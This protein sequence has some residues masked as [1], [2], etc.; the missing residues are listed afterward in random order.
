MDAVKL[1]WTICA[2]VVITA[3]P[4]LANEDQ[5]TLSPY[6]FVAGDEPSVEQFPLK[7][8]KVEVTISGVIAD[9]KVIQY[10]ENNGAAPINGSYIFPGSTRAAVHGMKMRIGERLITA[11]IKEKEAARQIFEA[12]K[13]AGKSASLLAQKRPNVFS[14]E[15]ANIMPGD[16]LTVELRYTELLIPAEGVYE[17]VY[18]TVVGPRY[19]TMDAETS[20]PSERWV[21]NPYL[22]EGDAPRTNFAISMAINAGMDIE[23]IASPSHDTIVSY[24]DAQRARIELAET[25]EFGG[26]RDVIVRYQLAGATISSGL[27]LHRGEDENF[28]LLMAQPP[29]RVK[30]EQIPAREYIFVVDVS[31]SMHGFPLNT[32]KKLMNRLLGGLRPSDRFNVLLFAG[33]SE[34][35]AP[36]SVPATKDGINKAIRFINDSEGGGGTEL[37]AAMRRAMALPRAES[38]S[39]SLAIITDGYINA[40]CSVFEEIE[41]NLG[42]TNVF[43]FGIGSGVNRYLIEGM[44]RAGRGYPFVVTEP[45]QAPGAAAQFADYIATPLLTEITLTSS[46]VELYD[47]EPAAIPDLFASRPILVYGKWKE[48]ADKAALTISGKS[49]GGEYRQ[50]FAFSDAEDGADNQPLAYLWARARIARLSDYNSAGHDD[51]LRRRIVSL[52]LTYNLLTKFTSFVAVDEIVRNPDAQA[53]DVKQP[54][55]LPKGVSNL[56]VG[57][58]MRNYSEPSLAHIIGLFVLLLGCFILRDYRRKHTTA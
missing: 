2:V 39:R 34:I 6:F 18:P 11:K 54:L 9:V 33:G 44:A 29:K 23:K 26:D 47:V 36:S 25:G 24:D 17:F 40:E 15:V 20:P 14:M 50:S 1:L 12:A 21:A 51:E 3:G 31:G 57:A 46:E 56:A 19:S 30:P 43:S 27:L 45:A 8:T 52:G 13:K 32:A 55:P 22:K 38:V 41:K 48:A 5:Q 10:Y 58:G 53:T 4:G 7:D 42:H 35:M 49:A 37:L 16:N 28:F